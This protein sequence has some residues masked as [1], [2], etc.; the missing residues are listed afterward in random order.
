MGEVM[1][2]LSYLTKVKNGRTWERS[3]LITLK[4]Q[5][6]E[7]YLLFSRPPFSYG[8]KES[9]SLELPCY[10]KIMEI[11]LTKEGSMWNIAYRI[12]KKCTDHFW[13]HFDITVMM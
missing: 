4:L 1:I 11:F 12:K 5:P 2:L 10:L 6:N 3:Q 13:H 9:E 7:K 8:K